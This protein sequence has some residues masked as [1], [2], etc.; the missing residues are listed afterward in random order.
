MRRTPLRAKR[1]PSTNDAEKSA[2]WHKAVVHPKATCVVCDRPRRATRLQGHHVISQQVLKRECASLE[3][4]VEQ[5]QDILWDHRNGIALCTRCHE[6]HTNAVERIRL[7]RLPARVLEF[8]HF[9]DS[10]IGSER[11]MSRLR[12]EYR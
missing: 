6:R 1:R 12:S 8:V 10:M 11:L 7:A 3:L 5:T 9:M 2:A 4:S